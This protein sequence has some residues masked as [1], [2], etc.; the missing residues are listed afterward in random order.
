MASKPLKYS[1]MSSKSQ[2]VLP[3]SLEYLI[4]YQADT[5]SMLNS[6]LSAQGMVLAV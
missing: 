3:P 2:E 1:Y 6:L 4:G 5:F